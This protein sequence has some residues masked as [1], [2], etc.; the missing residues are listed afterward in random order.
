MGLGTN[1]HKRPLPLKWP[2]DV[3][4]R[5]SLSYMLKRQMVNPDVDCLLYDLIPPFPPSVFPR[6]GYGNFSFWGTPSGNNSALSKLTKNC[7]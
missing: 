3:C 5:F 6:T 1:V 2:V 4:G 7:P